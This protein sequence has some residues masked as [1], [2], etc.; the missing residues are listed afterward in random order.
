MGNQGRYAEA[1]A[2]FRDILAIRCRPD[3]LG[4][5][6]PDTLTTRANIA[7]QMGYQGRYAEA[8]AEFRDILAIECRPE[9]LGEEH[10]DTLRTRYWVANMLGQQEKH[11]EALD[12][13]LGIE[14]LLKKKLPPEHEW[15]QELDELIRQLTT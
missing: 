1:E 15:C 14:P 9:A 11:K 5:E 10:P 8:E 13:T 12:I 6:H 3:V 4:E 7:Q 2:E